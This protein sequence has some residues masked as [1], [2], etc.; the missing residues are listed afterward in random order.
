MAADDD[1]GDGTSL[2]GVFSAS[3][4]NKDEGSLDIYA[5][6]D[7]AASDIPFTSSVPSRNCL[8]LYEEILTEEG[9]AKEATYNDLQL[10]YEKC[11]LQMKELMRKYKEIQTQNCSLKN[12]NQSLKKNISALIKTARV[13]INR[14]DEEISN[15]HQ[16]LSEF[17]HF[18]NNH[19]ISRSSDTVRA[20]D[21]KSRSPHL[22]ECSKTEPR[23]K[24]DVSRDVH[25][26][27]SLP[28][29]G[30]EGKSNP[31][32]RSTSLLPTS[33]EKHCTNGVWSRSHYQFGESNSS[34]DNR[35]EK[36]DTR[37][38]QYSGGTD[39]VRRDF[40]TS[41]GDSEPRNTETN[42]RLQG[43]PEKFDKGEPKAEGKHSKFKS[44]TD[45][46]HQ[47]E[48]GNSSWEKDISRERSHIRVESQNDRRL[49][50]QHQRSQNINRKDLK[51]QD[52]E[53]RKM[54]QN[55]KSLVKHQ[56]YWRRSKQT[57]LPHSR[58]EITKSSYNSGKY[59][60]E[61][62]RG[63]EEC[64]RERGVSSH[65]FQEGR[66][67]SLLSSNRAYRHADSKDTD[68]MHQWENAPLK[69]ERHRTEEKR[70]RDQESKDENRHMRNEKKT[71]TEHLQ[72]T[73][74]E[75]KKTV[76]DLKRQ[77]EPKNSKSEISE[78]VEDKELTVKGESGPNET[79]SKDFKLSFME[80]LNLTLSPAKKQP[81]SEEKSHKRTDGPKSNDACN[82][83]SSMQAETV[84]SSSEH[85]TEETKPK[86][87][88]KDALSA[89]SEH[90]LKTPESK[91]EEKNSL[92]VK[93]VEK[94]VPCDV[95]LCSVKTCLP[96]P[97][98]TN[99]SQPLSTERKETV[100]S[101]KPTTVVMDTLQ[102]D[103]SQNCD[104]KLDTKTSSGLK[105]SVS[106]TME[107]KA[108]FSAKVA[109]SRKCTTQPTFGET[110]I[111][112][113]I[114]SEARN[115]KLEPSLDTPLVESKSHHIEP[116]LPK[117]TIESSVQKTELMD[118]S[119]E[120]GE[121]NSV[122]HD[123]ENS[124][125]SID[126]N[127][128]RPIPEVISPLNSPVRP[129]AKV[130]RLESP[131]QLPLY[132]NSHKDVSPVNSAHSTSKTRSD[133]LN[134]E[135]QKPVCKTDKCTV[136]DFH[137]NSSS[138]E[139]EEGEIVSDNETAQPQKNFENSD[140]P[141]TSVQIENSKTNQGRRK[142]T[143]H[144]DEDNRKTSIKTHHHI[145]NRC[146]KRLT[147]ARQ[148][149]KLGKKDK[150]M[151]TASLEKI[152]QI[153]TAP[154]SIREVMQMLRMIRKHVRKNYMKFKVK[155][156][157]IQFHRIIESAVVSFTSLIKHL[158]LSKISK[159]VT[160]LQ[161]NLC[162]IIECK[163]KQVKKNGIVDRLFEQQLPDMKKKLWKFVDE[164]L[165]Y[166]FVK[167]KKILVKFCDFI[168]F[169]SDSDDGK[170]EKTNK[171]K[172][173]SNCQK[174]T[175]DN[176]TKEIIQVN[177][178][179]SENSVHFK[180]LLGCQK[181]EEKQQNQSNPSINTVQHDNKNSVNTC[182]NDIKNTQSKEQVVELS[183]PST[184]KLEKTD[185]S[186]VEDAQAS[187]HAA[188]K[189]ERG[190]EIL[191]EQQASSLTFNLVS[192]AQMGEIFKSL[193]QGSDLLDSTV[194]GNE[195]NEWELKTPEKQLLESLKCES[196]PACTTEEL[197]SGVVS[198]S[199]KMISE[200][201]WSLLSSEKGPSLSSR[202]SLPVHPDVLDESCMFEVSSN[203]SLSKDNLCNA[204]KSKPCISS[205]LLE[206]LA[207]SLTVPSP[208]K[209]DG[210]LSFLKPE[211]LS[212]STPEEV[213]SAHF[214]E[215]ALLE[216]EDASEQDIHLALES[217]NSSSKSSCSSSW[218]S[219]SVAPGFQYH[220]NL[221]MHAVIM[222]KSNDHFIVKIR[223]ATPSTTP[224]LKKSI[225]TDESLAY[226]PTVGKEAD[227]ATEKEYISCENSV[228]KSVAKLEKSSQNGGG[229]RLANEDQNSLIQTQVPDI[230]EFLK[231][232]SGKVNDSNE[233]AEEGFKLRQE[234]WGPNPPEIIEELP[235]VEETPP[236][237]ENHLP[238]TY[239][240]L[241]KDPVT[242][243]KNL[244]EFLEVTVLNI[245]QV[246][247]S[248]GNLDQNAPILDS[249][250]QLDT[251]R[252]F[253]DLTQDASTESKNDDNHSAVADG[254]VG[255]QVICV[256]E[257]NC[258]EEKQC[259]AKRPLECIAE[260][261]CIDLTT[262]SLSPC[263]VKDDL[264]SVPKPSFSDR[265]EL[266]GSLDNAHKKRKSVSDLNNSTQKKQRMEID[267][268]CKKKVKKITE[269]S[270]E[271][272]E[273]CPKKA[274][275]KRTPAVN[276]DP[277]S[278]NASPG[279]QDLPGAPTTSPL[280]LSA[281][282]VIK[283]K[284]EI[285]VSWTRNDDREILMECQKRGPS[286][287]TFTSLAAKLNKNPNQVSERFQQL[288]KLFEKL[289]CR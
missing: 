9:T 224:P 287:K 217:D 275:K 267:L 11:Q 55:P 129:V 96:V 164:Q 283:K 264:K 42:Q 180:S 210:H 86:V 200:D 147:E 139:L 25:H 188:L 256:E 203:V 142:S 22:D 63:R 112:P 207:V 69:T 114:I 211:V 90:R 268:T 238:N 248:G 198:P 140:K 108:S 74:K 246:E 49:E 62:R 32:K 83:E 189:P 197:V 191:T 122:Y 109:E 176:S 285:I 111:L 115:P 254:D 239:I 80:K 228:F 4:L 223:R 85:I 56:D 38:T 94:L 2:F 34:E 6:L 103:T 229:N 10:E 220:P 279:M 5:G 137:K 259:V 118:C 187:Q 213:I 15:L 276:N 263:E 146:S 289:K 104:S 162:D 255:C 225:M 92:F 175:V 155:F 116:C 87:E 52:K 242:E 144:L 59:H 288:M 93:S 233:G 163:L 284:G 271:N 76:T 165:D 127:H 101:P 231:D 60:L 190:F 99:Y 274:N 71:P 75:T 135:N 278:P 125:L 27:A 184:P 126:F 236:S 157:L 149:S 156:S 243:P 97:V 119:A 117:E 166:L 120:I 58:N 128:L 121:T 169:G 158:D 136:A 252:S 57:L 7:S 240:D 79:N 282:N 46:D 182:A 286:V 131:S 102:I 250:L 273:T 132:N 145:S 152:V 280:S 66:C 23:V 206:D 222:E 65:S 143:V 172:V 91:V 78:R 123:D 251:V 53:E 44:N 1:N 64:K 232:A 110:G 235:S 130:L 50:R 19:K 41:C 244:G 81:L 178:P 13:E 253:I 227:D 16:R 174:G 265:S 241:T 261:A 45:P 277:S 72:K 262:E 257:G 177:T 186:T 70:K 133:D 209:S 237:V 150:T 29:P 68:G 43:R 194:N 141:R 148:A 249:S 88:A 21:L 14:K 40:S 98:E 95:S 234:V 226:L 35:R 54:K 84:P 20:K 258:E 196:I 105:S 281:K 37:H 173:H 230:Y 219:R 8:D 12:E 160:T 185:K 48:H 61:E 183:C 201:N 47:S 113:V 134:K 221:P 260:E 218:T 269:E 193:L 161:K 181:S 30:K 159:S 171:E 77:N 82:L 3:P 212:S 67:S 195:K 192:D 204:E 106:E 39:R 208:L 245:D 151:S 138:D 167:L 28:N 270:G 247:C 205:I 51:T 215:D 89:A 154:S 18:R 168:N 100:D 199:P 31:E 107:I 179:K 272:D 216:E 17:P 266:P 36:K 26:S 33:T 214:S 202:L 170:F 73:D 153:I 24:N 124:V